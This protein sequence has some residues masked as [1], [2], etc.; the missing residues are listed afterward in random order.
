M[1]KRDRDV[2]FSSETLAAIMTAD[3]GPETAALIAASR[4][5][6]AGA[7]PQPA[8]SDDPGPGGLPVH[9]ERLFELARL[10]KMLGVL[11]LAPAALPP[12]CAGLAPRLLQ[13]HLQTVS[14]NRRAMAVTVEVVQALRDIRHVVLKGPFQQL[15]LHG[16]ASRRP[17]G[18]IDL[19]VAPRDRERAAD[20]LRRQ[21]FLPT[22]AERALWWIGF[23]GE[24]H[25][26]RPTD[27]AVVDLHHRLQQ[28]GLPDWRRAERVLDRAGNWPHEGVA[29]PMPSAVDGCLLLSVT[30]AK[31]L[32]AHEPCGWAAAELGH[33]LGQLP[34]SDWPKLWQVAQEAR[35]DRTLALGLALVSACY[36]PL[37]LADGS[38][39]RP[40]VATPRGM[41]QD[42]ALLRDLV[43]QPWRRRHA[44]DT[45]HPELPAGAIRRSQVLRM[46]SQGR[47]H[48]L[49]IEGTRA[50]LSPLVR[51]HLEGRS[52]GG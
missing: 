28:V 10:N 12:G 13:V 32:L 40:L 27:G 29:I 3:A 47:P 20:R 42:R 16:H 26:Q 38:P 9:S 41:P 25:L 22:E 48:V 39:A 34:A 11:P 8:G 44:K 49:A 17:S 33:W 7:A 5:G 30:L 6:T 46:L 1:A 24:Q 14:M 37:L 21:G 45:A 36:G 51:S 18:D 35:Q 31:A 52:K 2:E 19:Y 50:V 23:L 43:F 4:P 15:A